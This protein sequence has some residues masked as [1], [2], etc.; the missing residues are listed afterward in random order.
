MRGAQLRTIKNSRRYFHVSILYFLFFA[1]KKEK[2]AAQAA[3][4]FA[5]FALRYTKVFSSSCFSLLLTRPS[6]KKNIRKKEEKKYKTFLC[7]FEMYN[8]ALPMFVCVCE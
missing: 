6:Q 8:V 5:P 1:R 2:P 4:T 3:L 7:G